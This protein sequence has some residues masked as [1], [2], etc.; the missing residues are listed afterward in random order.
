MRA[1][2]SDRRTSGLL[3]PLDGREDRRGPGHLRAH[4]TNPPT[5]GG[6]FRKRESNGRLT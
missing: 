2:G 3:E 6:S 4:K 1:G 5:A